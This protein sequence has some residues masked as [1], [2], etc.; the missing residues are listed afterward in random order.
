M[1]PK[2]RLSQA[3]ISFADAVAAQRQ[4]NA[5]RYNFAGH[6]GAAGH[7]HGALAL[8]I[9]GSRCEVA[10]K[11]YLDP[12]EWNQ[13]D[14]NRPDFND[15]IDVK[16]I[17]KR[18]HKLTVQRRANDHYAYFLVYGGDHPDYEMLGWCFGHEA[19]KPVFWADPTGQCRP[20]YFVPASA[21]CFKSAEQLRDLIR[22]RGAKWE[23]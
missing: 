17:Q 21:Q 7:G 11:S 22:S 14:M 3:Q 15:W 19:K 13:Y 6:N 23:R 18:W 2:I 9:L 4:T 20:A 16:G 12:V 5:D 1:N 8:H 10:A